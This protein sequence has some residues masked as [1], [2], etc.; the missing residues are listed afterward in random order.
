MAKKEIAGTTVDVNEEGYLTNPSQWT[1]EI[2]AV[3][4]QEEGIKNLSEGHWKV[5]YFLREDYEKSGKMPTI[6]RVKKAGGI[7]TK[8]LYQLYPEGPLKKASRIAGL[9]KPESCI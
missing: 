1:K 2:A 9:P 4:A 6:R 3:I 8:D 5:I 7:P